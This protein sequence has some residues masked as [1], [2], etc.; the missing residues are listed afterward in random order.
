MTDTDMLKLVNAVQGTGLAV[1]WHQINFHLID[2][3][4]HTRPDPEWMANYR[5]RSQAQHH[6]DAPAD[7]WVATVNNAGVETAYTATQGQYLA[8]I[9]YY[10]KIRGV[11]PAEADMQRYFKVSP[12]SVHNMVVTLEKRQLI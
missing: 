6:P 7:E 1:A 9:Y 2:E 3:P 10:S 8:F 4:A 11:P 12:P 5:P